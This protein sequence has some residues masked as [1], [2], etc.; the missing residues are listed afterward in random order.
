MAEVLSLAA[1]EAAACGAHVVLS[2][3]WGGE[4]HFGS[5]ATFVD[6]TPI[7]LR[8]AIEAAMAIPRQTPEQAADFAARF[9][10]DAVAA[11]VADVYREVLSA[12]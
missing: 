11:S 3:T 5:R 8:R 10:W 7:A 2:N 12:G 4:E 9:T 6:P 1:L